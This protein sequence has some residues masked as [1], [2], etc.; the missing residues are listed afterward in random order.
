MKCWALLL[1]ACLAACGDDST[2]PDRGVGREF[3]FDDP[4]GDT[5]LFAESVDSFP[6]LDASRVSG[7]VRS[8]SLIL[9]IEFANPIARASSIVPNAMIA[10]IAVDADDDST[11]G[12]PLDNG[13]GGASSFT[14]PFP[15]TTGI[16]AEYIVFVDPQSGGNAD[17]VYSLFIEQ[18][19]ATYPIKYEEN[20]A[21]MQIPLSILGIGAGARFRIVGLV[22]NPQRLT[23]IFPNEG[24]YLLG[25]SP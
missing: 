10:T 23:D 5:A 18:T 19:V 16:G 13:S 6:A 22:G 15:A 7:T 3:T 25:E 2:G 8:D 17:V 9:K 4:V 1:L 21:S 12:L 14:A 20:S 11:T 24:N